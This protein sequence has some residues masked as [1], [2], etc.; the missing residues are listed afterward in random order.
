[1]TT[2]TQPLLGVPVGAAIVQVTLDGSTGGRE[3]NERP[4]EQQVH[5]TV[6]YQ[7]FFEQLGY[8]VGKVKEAALTY[9]VLDPA[10][11]TASDIATALNIFMAGI[12]ET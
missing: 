2:S 4:R 8:E 7:R 1:M 9:T 10:T 6:A 5:P 11:A 12:T 3:R